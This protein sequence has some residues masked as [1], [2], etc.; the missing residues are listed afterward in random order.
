M[1]SITLLWWTFAS[2]AVMLTFLSA[3]GLLAFFENTPIL[4]EIRKRLS[5]EKEEDKLNKPLFNPYQILLG[6]FFISTVLIFIPA[7]YFN[8]IDEQITGLRVIKSI[9]ISVV[10]TIKVFLADSDY[11]ELVQSTFGALTDKG[12][13]VRSIYSVYAAVIHVAGPIFTASFIL[14]FFKETMSLIRLRLHKKREYV[15]IMSE[16][17][18]RSLALAKDIMSDKNIPRRKKLI[19]FTDVFEKDDDRVHEL[20]E[21]AKH[22]GALCVKK[23]ITGINLKYMAKDKYRKLYFL[24]ENEEKNIKQ[25]LKMIQNAT[26]NECTDVYETELYVFA[27]TIESEAL[28]DS[29]DKKHIKVRRINE[30]KNL[31]YKTMHDYPIYNDAKNGA[32]NIAIVGLGGYGTELLKTICQLGQVKDYCVNVHAFE[33]GEGEDKIKFVAPELVEYSHKNTVGNSVY[34][35][36]FYDNIDVTK[37]EF[38][39]KLSSI[40]SLSSVYVTLGD[41]E[42]NIQTAMRIRS[43]LAR[44]NPNGENIPIYAVVFSKVKTDM[45][46]NGMGLRT[47]NREEFKITFIGS[48]TDLCN[49]ETIEQRTNEP[50]A[51]SGHMYWSDFYDGV[52]GTIDEKS[53]RKNIESFEKYEYYRKSSLAQAVFYRILNKA[54]ITPS[55]DSIGIYE[56]ARWNVFMRSE[57]FVLGDKRDF[58]KKTHNELVDFEKLPPLEKEKDLFYDSRRGYLI[59]DK[60]N[61]DS[62]DNKETV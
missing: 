22:L 1:N 60:S 18:T 28:L 55:S 30:N 59:I 40:D 46:G 23:D 24:S 4:S 33:N 19:I 49:L 32:L 8:V 6:G 54:K 50:I 47:T 44:K 56:H 34:G 13:I 58:V 14:S 42:L 52:Y 45:L 51:R 3:S 39:E 5:R 61:K 35:I 27:I 29:I 36:D 41:D 2:M 10:N 62:K 9:L 26:A 25:A 16:L 31:V 57:G 21:N 43:C 48:L 12:E 15:Y 7:N 38:F 11:S 53:R 37:T 20:I 17:N